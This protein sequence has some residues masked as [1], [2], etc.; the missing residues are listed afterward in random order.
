MNTSVKNKYLIIG[1][2]LA[3]SCLAM[4]LRSLGQE[5]LVIDA[6][7]PNSASRISP[8][9]LNPIIG[10]NL[11]L[12][13]EV[14]RLMNYSKDFFMEYLIHQP[15]LKILEQERQ[16]EI[17][18]KRIQDPDFSKYLSQT[19]LEKKFY[20]N[21]G[22]FE[23]KNSY[24][25]QGIKFLEDCRKLLIE[26][27]QFQSANYFEAPQD[28]QDFDKIIFCTGNNFYDLDFLETRPAR[29]D[30]LTL[31]IPELSTDYIYNFGN[32]LLPLKENSFLLGAT[33]SWDNFEQER[34]QNGTENLL[35]NFARIFQLPYKVVSHTWGIRPIIAGR[36]PVV[37][38]HPEQK[39]VYFLNGLG[40]KGCLYAPFFSKLLAEHLVYGY[41]L[42]YEDHGLST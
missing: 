31:E 29:G 14:D 23:V 34:D 38:Q 33:Y 37:C 28:Y 17:F 9:I 36:K 1:Q 41:S 3:G 7:L 6:D 2:G 40:S 20:N 10:K 11:N 24:Y 12:T 19:E 30:L 16:C 18:S 21:Y 13:W 8:F 25:L 4:H 15:M 35:K 42:N 22:S 26:N 5:I 39:N 27:S 32:W